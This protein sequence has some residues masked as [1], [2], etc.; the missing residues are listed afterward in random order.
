MQLTIYRL[1]F[2]KIVGVTWND[3][4]TD[5]EILTRTGQRRLQDMALEV[6]DDY[7]LHYINIL[8]YLFTYLLTYLL[9]D[10]VA[11]R[12]RLAGHIIQMASE[13]PVHYVM[14]GH[15]LIGEEEVG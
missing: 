5:A 3:K 7:K 4:V 1:V 13:R 10:I 6:L 15:Q 14:D 8:T 2:K 11:E 12:F 9:Q